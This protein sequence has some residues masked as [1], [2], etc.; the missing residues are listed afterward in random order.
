MTDQLPHIEWKEPLKSIRILNTNGTVLD[1]EVGNIISICKSSSKLNAFFKIDEF[2]GSVSEI[3]PTC[4]A[5]REIDIVK[6]EFVETKF[7][8]KT[9]GKRYIICYPSGITKYGFH[10]SNEEWC[11]VAICKSDPM[12]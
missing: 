8:L 1:V 5:Y 3:G 10:L 6:K 11:S 12:L 9:G 4:F 2:F 7:S